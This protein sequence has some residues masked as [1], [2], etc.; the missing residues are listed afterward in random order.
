MPSFSELCEKLPALKDLDGM[1]E[2]YSELPGHARGVVAEYV[3][4]E[5]EKKKKDGYDEMKAKERMQKMLAMLERR[6]DEDM[7]SCVVL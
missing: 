5:I 7:E 6:K 3:D 1:E 2:R 4:L